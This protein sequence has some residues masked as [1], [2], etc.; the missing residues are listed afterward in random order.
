MIAQVVPLLR[1]PRTLG[2]FDY[3]TADL[4]AT[5]RPGHLVV[6]PFRQGRAPA[7]VW[8]I[9]PTPARAEFPYKPIL[10]LLAPQPVFTPTQ[11]TLA[12][13]VA[14]QYCQSLA[15]VAKVIAPELPTR[16]QTFFSSPNHWSPPAAPLRDAVRRELVV[17]SPAEE[18]IVD[19]CRSAL[20]RRQ[21][22]LMV[23]PEVAPAQA[24]CEMLRRHF[25]DAVV[26]WPERH[27][28][29][30][31]MTAWQTLLGGVPRLV[32]GTRRAVFAPLPRLGLVIIWDEANPS[33][34]QWDQNPRY[35]ARDVAGKLAE[36][37]RADVCA[38]SAAPTVSSFWE[39]AQGRARLI[40]MPPA[41]APAAQ[42]VDLRQERASGNF[43]WLSRAAE[44]AVSDAL[45]R[46]GPGLRVIVVVNRKGSA[47]F[48]RCRECGYVFRCPRCFLPFACHG[49]SELGDGSA[50]ARGLSLAVDL[51]CHRCGGTAELPP[52]C[53][54][55][56]GPRVRPVGLGILRALRLLEP[57]VAGGSV[58]R[59]DGDL[60]ARRQLLV[61]RE[62]AAG[63]IVGLVTTQVGL[64]LLAGVSAPLVVIVTAD[65]GLQQ[66]DFRAAERTYHLITGFARYATDHLII[67]T[68]HP[69]HPVYQ[70]VATGEAELFYRA[71][72]DARREFHYPPFGR[73]VLLRF[74]HKTLGR[75]E[76]EARRVANIL[77]HRLKVE[78]PTG[79]VFG[80]ERGRTAGRTPSWQL[81]V[82][83][84][85]DP[86]TAAFQAPPL[87]RVY[88]WWR[89]ALNDLPD[90]WIVDVD[91]EEL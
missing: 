3:V 62:L 49:G 52:L 80:P 8:K 69:E 29:I 33:L 58:R 23:V 73:I 6:V 40:T 36:L 2:V 90:G 71:E 74:R 37:S 7:I 48:V 57:L 19:R 17:G 24:L 53:P 26:W 38:V 56:H 55:C 85:H 31:V 61:Q 76:A 91:P 43:L 12:E 86:G 68:Y 13:W 27:Q 21:Q 77:R 82:K 47:A 20:S 87:T 59:L 84:P 75:A 54:R 10:R 14:A 89:T 39:A 22:V 83:F 15:N 51:R 46:S 35:H 45:N 16:P 9:K 32:V 60:S 67:Q 44:A 18:W 34:K 63:R 64:R 65:L 81:W 5:L 1:L 25:R 79:S 66:P 4:A 41:P 88:P 28:R 72:W 42:L 78:L 70:A 50:G 11:L 30:A